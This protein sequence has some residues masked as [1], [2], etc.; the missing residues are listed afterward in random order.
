MGDN[1]GESADDEDEVADDVD[2]EGPVDGL[3]TPH[4]GVGNIGT[5]KRHGVLP[6]LVESGNTG[7]SLLA[8]AEDTR[9]VGAASG[10]LAALRQRVLDV[11]G[12]CCAGLVTRQEN[13]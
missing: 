6:K 8:H 5:K 3:V 11:V 2:A 10:V 1:R 13:A 12:D 4:V 7:R 9:K